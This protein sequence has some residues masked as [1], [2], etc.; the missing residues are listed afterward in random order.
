MTT[1]GVNVTVRAVDNLTTS[2]DEVLAALV[3]E[4]ALGADGP[5]DA[6]AVSIWLLAG[7]SCRIGKKKKKKKLYREERGGSLIASRRKRI[8]VQIAALSMAEPEVVP[9]GVVGHEATLDRVRTAVI[10]AVRVRVVTT[11][12]HSFRLRSQMVGF[13]LDVRTQG[14]QVL[15]QWHLPDAR[16]VAAVDK[17][18]LSAGDDDAGVDGVRGH[19]RIFAG[20]LARAGLDNRAV[21][22]PFARA[23]MVR[24]GHTNGTVPA[25]R[26]ANSVVDV[27]FAVDSNRI[28]GPWGGPITFGDDTVGIQGVT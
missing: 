7:M 17:V 23:W 2:V 25:A 12:E 8:R 22:L 21:V 19:E 4:G 10:A 28:G 16:P 26:I 3:L 18:W 6:D 9:R 14:D 1:G 5:T 11:G 20:S 27:I 13:T 15:G 24:N